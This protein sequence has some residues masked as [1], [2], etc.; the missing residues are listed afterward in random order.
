MSYLDISIN[1]KLL[2][3]IIKS[4]IKKNIKQFENENL[5]VCGCKRVKVGSKIYAGV[6][7]KDLDILNTEFKLNQTIVFWKDNIN[8]LFE[9]DN[10]KY[11][12]ININN[13]SNSISNLKF[14]NIRNVNTLLQILDDIIEVDIDYICKELFI[15]KPPNSYFEKY[16]L[17]INK[18]TSSIPSNYLYIFNKIKEIYIKLKLKEKGVYNIQQELLDNLLQA[19]R[20]WDNLSIRT[21]SFKSFNKRLVELGIKEDSFKKYIFIRSGIISGF[22]RKTPTLQPLKGQI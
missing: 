19:E 6:I 16:L 4:N 1:G 21:K 8:L 12:Y 5:I 9:Y 20:E 18:V 17:I 15:Y 22:V 14:E 13:V 3:E 7:V 11:Y 2:K 10:I